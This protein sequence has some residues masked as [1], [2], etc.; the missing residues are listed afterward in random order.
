MHCCVF[1]FTCER[2]TRLAQKKWRDG[3]NDLGWRWG[4]GFLKKVFQLLK[5]KYTWNLMKIILRFTSDKVAKCTSLVESLF[6]WRIYY[7]PIKGLVRNLTCS[8]EVLIKFLWFQPLAVIIQD[9]NF[10]WRLI[11]NYSHRRLWYHIF[12]AEKTSKFLI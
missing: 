1:A 5:N 11:R 10:T 8:L 7:I 12:R 4:G 6:T 2:C 3:L 9:K